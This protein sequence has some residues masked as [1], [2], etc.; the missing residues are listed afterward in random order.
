MS[1][2]GEEVR[3]KRLVSVSQLCGEKKRGSSRAE[4]DAGPTQ[5]AFLPPPRS[6]SRG[7]TLALTSDPL[8]HLSR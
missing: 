3:D 7:Q 5:T 1:C 2:T 8:L 6:E 4:E